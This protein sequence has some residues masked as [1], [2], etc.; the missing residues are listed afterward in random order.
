MLAVII[1]IACLFLL[2][3]VLFFQKSQKLQKRLAIVAD[4]HNQSNFQAEA[5]YREMDESH[6]K[7]ISEHKQQILQLEERYRPVINVDET[8]KQRKVQI[9]EANAQM[10]SLAERY[11]YSL[12]IYN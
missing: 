6:L 8:L 4:E 9:A 11:R 2:L 5:T 3:F 10:T 12:D 1:G 7:T